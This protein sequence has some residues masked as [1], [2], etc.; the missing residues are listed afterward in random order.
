M[1]LVVTAV[2]GAMNANTQATMAAAFAII[3]MLCSSARTGAPESAPIIIRV[4]A[5]YE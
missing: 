3:P 2:E 1:G 5:R 4:S